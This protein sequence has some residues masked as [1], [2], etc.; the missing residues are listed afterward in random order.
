M[1]ELNE[2]YLEKTGIEKPSISIVTVV[3]NGEKYIEKT[4]KNVLNQTYKNIR[5]IIIDGGSTDNTINIIKKYEQKLYYWISEQDKGIYDAMNKA[6]KRC[7][8]EWINFMNA[9][10]VFY[11]DETIEILFRNQ[12]EN[13]IDIIYG[14]LK[15]DYGSFQR[16]E[17]AKSLSLF[18]K[19][20]SFSHQSCFIK[21]S[22]HKNNLYSLNYKIAGDFEFF[23]T[24]YIKNKEFK[25]IPGVVS[26]MDVQGLS[27]SNRFKSIFQR[28]LIVN[29]LDFKIKYN[30]YY[31]FLYFDQCFRKLLKLFLPINIINLIKKR[32]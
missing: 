11:S 20:M 17:D 3:F 5:Y 16:I 25:Y 1:N 15:I 29:R 26:I 6:I 23:Y 24:A 22:F 10:D 4:I 30:I 2:N 27:D 13:Q 14:D 32:K 18:W 28:H 7:D 19:G 8:T 9:G 31:M 21:A 12:I